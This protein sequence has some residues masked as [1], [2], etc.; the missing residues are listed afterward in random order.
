MSDPFIHPA[1]GYAAVTK[2]DTTD[3]GPVRS[4]Y[5]GGTGD[6]VI[7]NGLTG[8]GITFSAVPAGFVLPVQCTRVLAATT[9]TL[10]VALY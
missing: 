10:I 8:A 3:L 1:A 5:V 6:V 2:S 9:A 4:L 7:S